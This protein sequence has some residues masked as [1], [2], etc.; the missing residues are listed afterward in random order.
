[1]WP[2][3][4]GRVGENHIDAF[5]RPAQVAQ[6]LGHDDPGKGVVGTEL[7]R[8][9]HLGQR[10]LRSAGEVQHEGEGDV[11]RDRDRI[12]GQRRLHLRDRLIEATER[13][14]DVHSERL[15]RLGLIG[16]PFQDRAELALGAG[17]VPVVDRM[18]GGQRG[19]R[20]RQLRVE[21]ERAP[22]ELP[23]ALGNVTRMRRVEET[24]L[25]VHVRQA[26]VGRGERWDPARSP[27]RRAVSPRVSRAPSAGSSGTDP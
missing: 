15:A 10:L 23:G 17:P 5:V 16:A 9:P 7:E 20:L 8:G 14:Q 12:D 19:P 22:A 26:D 11:E 25:D 27:A 6:D 2:G 24:E 18:D 21:V 1:M 4:L 3:H 13:R